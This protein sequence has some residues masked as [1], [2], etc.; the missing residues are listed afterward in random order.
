M[1]FWRGVQAA[2]NASTR[3]EV[4]AAPIDAITCWGVSGFRAAPPQNSGVSDTYLKTTWYNSGTNTLYKG[5]AFAL[6]RSGLRVKDSG[7]RVQ[8]S[9][10][11]SGC[12]VQGVGFRM[13]G[14]GCRVWGAGCRVQGVWFRVQGVGFRV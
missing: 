14:S 5:G 2:E 6:G 7:C 13:K 11:R 1:F 12:R 8:G 9:G 3:S 10:C 4:K